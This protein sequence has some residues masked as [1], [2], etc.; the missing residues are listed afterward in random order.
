MA[1]TNSKTNNNSDTVLGGQILGGALTAQDI[2]AAA[3]SG[4]SQNAVQAKALLDAY[5]KTIGRLGPLV[6]V[7][8]GYATDGGP[9][10]VTSSASSYA[11]LAAAETTASALGYGIGGGP[12]GVAGVTAFSVLVGLATSLG[13]DSVMGNQLLDAPSEIAIIC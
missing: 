10:A 1:D 2:A 4:V 12:W 7:T 3:A 8:Y 9:G 11:G 5:G 6:S 13:A